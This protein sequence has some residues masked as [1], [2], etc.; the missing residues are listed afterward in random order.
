F[1]ATVGLF[2][3]ASRCE[4]GEILD[5]VPLDVLQFHGDETPAECEGHGR[6]WF[7][8]LRVKAGEDIEAQAARYAGASAILLDTCVAGVPGGTG[9]MVD[10]S[11]V[12][13]RFPNPLIFSGC[14]SA[15]T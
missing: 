8:A 1:I 2:V 13:D 3:N 5:A 11:L 6:P 4:V 10:W 9:E 14:M 15:L 7:K 12:P